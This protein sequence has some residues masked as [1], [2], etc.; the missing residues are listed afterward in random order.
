MKAIVDL[1]LICDGYQHPDVQQCQQ[2]IQ[3]VFT[4]VGITETKECTIRIVDREESAELNQQYRNITGAT[5]VLSFPFESPMEV[6][7]NLLGDLVICAPLVIAQAKVQNKTPIMHWTHLI[8]HGCLHLLG[9]DHEN[10]DEA[11]EMEDL[12]RQIMANMGYAD[13]YQMIDPL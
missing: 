4:G 10:D 7:I 9:Y 12:E 1:Q 13:P 5:N 2:I 11:E 3:E 6:E 8:V